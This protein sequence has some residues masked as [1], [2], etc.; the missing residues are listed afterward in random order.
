MFVAGL[1]VLSGVLFAGSLAAAVAHAEVC[2]NEVLR[3]ELNSS[4]LPDCRAYELVTPPYE[5]GYP[6]FVESFASSG[7]KVFIYGYANLAGTPG[8]GE[9]REEIYLDRRTDAGWKLSPLNASLG[10]FIGQLP[11]A[12]EADD[13]MTL[14]SQHTPSQS[15]Q[16]RELYVQAESGGYS[17]IGPLNP[18]PR[19]S[20]GSD[21]IE[22]G[23]RDYTAP[24]AATSDYGHVV[25]WASRPEDYWSFDETNGA[26]G[27]LYEYS[28]TENEHPMLVGVDGPRGSR[29]LIGECGTQLGSGG[30]GAAYNALSSSGETIFFTVE[31]VGYVGCV[32]RAPKFAEVY[33]RLRGSQVS[34]G[35][36]EAVDVSESECTEACGSESGKEFEGASENG[37]KVFFTSTQKLTDDASDLTAGGNAA[38]EACAAEGSGG[39]NLYLYDFAKAVHGR[40]S[41]VAGGASD[42]LGVA[43]MAEDGARVYFVA[44]GKIAGAGVNEFGK[45]PVEGSPNLYVY[46][47]D[48]GGTAF[49]ATLGAQDREV[50]R[51]AFNHPVEVTGEDGRFL[52]FASSAQGVTPDDTGGPGLEQ[53]FEYNAEGESGDPEVGELVRVT[54]GENGYA[55]NG[56]SV[57]EG[58]NLY[59]V[60]NIAHQVGLGADFKSLS[61]RLNVSGDGKTVVFE[62]VGALSGRALSASSLGCSSVYEFHS[63]GPISDGVVSLLSDGRDVQLNKGISC[64]A[65]FEAMD[66]SGDNVLLSSADELVPA[67]TDG[68]QRDI[69]DARVGGGFA[70]APA[71]TPECQGEGCQG[72]FSSAPGPV[73]PGSLTQAPEASVSAPVTTSTSRK[74]TKK[75][76]TK[77]A[78]G[79]K[80]RQGKCVTSKAKPKKKPKAGRA[81]RHRAR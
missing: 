6:L 22:P 54:Q 76:P 69:Y 27:S 68:A 26:G 71:S 14:W 2:A 65:Q 74:N 19:G 9:S 61:N 64:G 25:V 10:R 41:L 51:A 24:L 34:D 60:A 8:V 11:L 67:D 23:P 33:A 43:G 4:F 55:N 50:W 3:T 79:K 36:A 80:R 13:G 32:A 7:E 52:L 21:V 18:T 81:T 70:P 62:T 35:E 30:V 5:E 63:A 75:K 29:D 44:T 66:G 77:C 40:L 45:A 49:I 59:S 31:P 16:T 37:E 20:E 78:K 72:T 42:V 1:T 58:I 38:E 15:A 53:L 47:T 39:C 28:G 12:F 73:A 48:T 56:N 57:S 46:D 17:R